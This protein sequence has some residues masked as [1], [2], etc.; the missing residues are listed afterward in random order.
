MINAQIRL[1]RFVESC[2]LKIC[3]FKGKIVLFRITMIEGNFPQ[4]NASKMM[5]TDILDTLPLQDFL[6]WI[7]VTLTDFL[8]N[9]KLFHFFIFTASN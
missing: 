2:L 3:R 5:P 9:V 8:E 4:V 7:G 1:F 6:L